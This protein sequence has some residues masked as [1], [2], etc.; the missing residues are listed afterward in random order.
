MFVSNIVFSLSQVG[1]KYLQKTHSISAFEQTFGAL[2]FS[3]PGLI[4][5]WW[6]MDGEIPISLT[7]T[8]AYA[9]LYL[10]VIG[11]LF[12]FAAYFSVLNHLPVVVVSVIP[13]ITPAFALWLGALLL[14]EPLGI[15][16]MIG[17]AF[18]VMALALYD[19]V[20]SQFIDK[21]KLSL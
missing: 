12:G 19:G 18:I 7:A 6:L 5:S 13:L 15:P 14:N 8:S 2:A 17:T 10:A 4:I 9:V 3:M 1:V 21:G 20:F 16:L 11:S